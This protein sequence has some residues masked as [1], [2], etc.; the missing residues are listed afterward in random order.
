MYSTL[1]GVK[2]NL[3]EGLYD[4]NE[5]DATIIAADVDTVIWINGCLNRTSDFSELELAGDDSLIRLASNYFSACSIMLDQLEGHG[6]DDES[7]AKYKCAAARDAVWM[8][9]KN[10]DQIP[11]FVLPSEDDIAT[12]AEVQTDYGYATG[13]DAVCILGSE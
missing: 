7:L 4:E 2:R 3:Q 11:A 10:H 12:T 13:S 6:V 5:I 8:W 9:C 1:D